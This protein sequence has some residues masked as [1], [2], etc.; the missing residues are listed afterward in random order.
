MNK[1]NIFIETLYEFKR[2]RRSI[3]FHIFITLAILGLI[4]YQFTFLSKGND[5]ISIKNLLQFYQDWPSLALASAIPFKSAYYFNIIQLIFI[6]CCAV[7]NS[8]SFKLGTKEA[9]HTHSQ[10]NNEIV[11]GNF[12]GLLLVITIL[13][14]IL[15]ATSIL[16]NAILYPES[17]RL[18]YYLFYWFTLTFPA[19]IYFLGISSLVTRFIRHSGISLM[20]LLL[21]LGGIILGGAT[22]FH[23]V[24]DPCARNI[25]NMFS[26]F[27]GHSNLV[28][29]LLQRGGIFFTGISF[30]VLSIIPFPRI[31]NYNRILKNSIGI[32]CFFLILASCLAL[33]YL[34]LHWKEKDTREIY[35]QVYEKYAGPSKTRITRHDLHVKELADGG[36]S[37]SS[38][39]T[40]KNKTSNEVPLIMYL[41]PGF[42]INSIEIDGQEISFRKEHQILIINKKLQ[43]KDSCHVTMKYR[44]KIENAICNLNIVPEKHDSPQ[45][46]SLGIYHYGNFPAFC[47]K[48]YKLFPIECIWY[49]M[50]I[51]PYSRLGNPAINF[52]RYSLKVEHDPKLTAI[53]QGYATEEKEGITSFHFKH[54]MP[55]ISLCI[56]N[57]KK[58]TL[59]LLPRFFADTTSMPNYTTRLTLYYHPHHEYLL[60]RFDFEE[61]KL[62]SILL[63]AKQTIESKECLSFAEKDLTAEELAMVNTLNDGTLPLQRLKNIV[64]AKRDFDPIQH[65]PYYWQIFVETPCNYHIYSRLVQPTGEREQG[66]MVFIPEKLYSITKYS[67][68]KPQTEKEKEQFNLFLWPI[69]LK[70]IFEDG[71]CSIIPAFRGRT[72]YISTDENPIINN[73]IN[74]II[75]QDK[76]ILP[77]EWD[78]GEVNAIAYLKNKSL[79]EALHEHSLSSEKLQ[80]II[81]KKSAELWMY[82]SQ[83]IQVHRDTLKE[84]YHDF[85][86]RNQFKEIPAEEF[87]Q[88]FY[89]WT[90]LRLDSLIDH[91]YNTKQV[92]RL[93]IRNAKVIKIEDPEEQSFYPEVLYSFSVFNESDVPGIV[94]T[95]DLQSWII[96]PHEGREIQTKELKEP[97]FRTNRYYLN[98]PFSQNFPSYVNLELENNVIKDTTRKITHID[99]ITFWKQRNE[100]EIIVDN[101]DPGFRIVKAKGFKLLSLFQ[102]ENNYK[103]YYTN[104]RQQKAW[105]PVINHHFYGSPIQSAYIKQADAGKQKVE[106]NTELP[107]EGKYEV[108][109]YH[110]SPQDK[111]KDPRQEFYYSVFDG[112][113]EHEVVIHV[114]HDEIGWISLGV[115]HFTKEAKVTLCDR[116][117]KEKIESKYDGVAPQELTADA[118]KWVRLQE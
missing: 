87:Y 43:A 58:R 97:P 1:D 101:E 112:T 106:W 104:Y 75:F 32:A 59:M 90:N 24:L 56:G 55:G 111:V 44:G 41:N 9:L 96:P 80:N 18:S 92:P 16:F 3:L 20:V 67:N 118:I 52:T 68:R 42:K 36:I 5:A 82:I 61:D 117:R 54:D 94:M 12:L 86:L 84:F 50:C 30:L 107:Q 46:N 22:L 85:L 115:F 113:Q 60:E 89:Q 81:H 66:G 71:I 95:T 31:P 7:N 47:E 103:A 23:G 69:T 100:N 88:Q 14:W 35:R 38:H 21:T 98:R 51:S 13:N 102:K 48:D 65:Y 53:S 15:F 34:N 91:W 25:P 40:I 10:G 76:N 73:I 4:F 11:A 27:T 29:Y 37:V 105:T 17:F 8:R 26:D 93:E 83:Q 57:Y 39:M 49:P 110:P 62:A 74:N 6:A 28:N 108:F 70:P 63:N 72:F 19:S 64:L 116:D 114:N 2:T 79:K 33:F 99:S 78:V 77:Q 109:F 45:V